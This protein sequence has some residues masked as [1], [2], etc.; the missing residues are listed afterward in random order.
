MPFIVHFNFLNG[1]G[2]SEVAGI[3]KPKQELIR[4]E[5]IWCLLL[6]IILK[7]MNS[8]FF[9][10]LVDRSGEYSANVFAVFGLIDIVFYILFGVQACLIRFTLLGGVR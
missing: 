9:E 6:Q 5:D 2:E 3:M 7:F 1:L 8:I 10:R 4:I